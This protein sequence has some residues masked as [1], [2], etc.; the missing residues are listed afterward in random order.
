MTEETPEHQLKTL[1]EKIISDDHNS[2]NADVRNLIWL[3]D[4]VTDQNL[5]RDTLKCIDCIHG[6][7][8]SAASR[9]TGSIYGSS[10][11]GTRG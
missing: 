1:L 6:K 2:T 11:E 7:Y 9:E 4:H 8:L 10:S 5:K 3:Y